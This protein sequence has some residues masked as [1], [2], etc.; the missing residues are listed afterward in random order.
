MRI[1][2]PEGIA[3][4]FIARMNRDYLTRKVPDKEERG[5][6]VVRRFTRRR[7]DAEFSPHIRVSA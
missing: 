3:T 5:K 6:R 1:R 7:G 4:G 2:P